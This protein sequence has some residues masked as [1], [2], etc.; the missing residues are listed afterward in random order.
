MDPASP[1]RFQRVEK[2][3]NLMTYRHTQTIWRFPKNGPLL[4]VAVIRIIVYL[5][6]F[7]GRLIDGNP[8]YHFRGLCELFVA[9]LA[10]QMRTNR[11][12]CLLLEQQILEAR[13]SSRRVCTLLGCSASF[14]SPLS[15]RI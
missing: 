2:D 11:F 9:P 12:A 8:P 3:K 14:V 15:I 7:W 10:K 13:E 6:L 4:G 1:Q 5:G